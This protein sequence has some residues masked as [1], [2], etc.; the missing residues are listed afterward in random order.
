MM[1]HVI[2][3]DTVHWDPPGYA[4]ELGIDTLCWKSRDSKPKVA[5]LAYV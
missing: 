3:A 5:W 2:M 1:Y 4:E